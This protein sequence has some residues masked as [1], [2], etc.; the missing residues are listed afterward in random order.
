LTD[1]TNH[2]NKVELSREWYKTQEDLKI[3]QVKEKELRKAVIEAYFGENIGKGTHKADLKPGV[4]LSV[5]IGQK[6]KLV[7][8][9]FKSYFAELQQRGFIHDEGLIRPKYEV[10]ASALKHLSDSDKIKF[11]DMFEYT[12]ESPQL[13]VEVKE[14]EK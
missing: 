9:K 13:K 12:E 7:P 11:A 10:S 8:D 14:N 5:S 1:T 3:L 4:K 6:I 2:D